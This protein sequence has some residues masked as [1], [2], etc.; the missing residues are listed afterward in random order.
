MRAVSIT[1]IPLKPSL[2]VFG[3][4]R[5]GNTAVTPAKVALLLTS[6]PNYEFGCCIFPAVRSWKCRNRREPVPNRKPVEWAGTE[7][8]TQAG[9]V[10]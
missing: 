6:T 3:D 4:R 5:Q 7:R 1:N 9:V 8:F 10:R 2:P